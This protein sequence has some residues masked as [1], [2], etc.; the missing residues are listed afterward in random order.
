MSERI[1]TKEFVEKYRNF[2]RRIKPVKSPAIK[3]TVYF[4]M[5]GFKHLIFKGKHRRESKAI[6]NRLVLVPLIA[7]VIHNCDEAQE[8]RIRKEIID[9]KK[10][11]VTYHTLEAHVGKDSVRVRVITRKVGKKGRHYFH[12]VMKY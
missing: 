10:V 11:R 1:A 5:Y 9:G 8:I 7:P 4:N 3:D 6:L 2:Y 12:S